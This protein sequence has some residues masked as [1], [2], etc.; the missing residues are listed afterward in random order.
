MGKGGGRFVWLAPFFCLLSLFLGS[1]NA[2]ASPLAL[3]ELLTRARSQQ[4]GQDPAWQRL[5]FYSPYAWLGR[6]GVIDDPNFYA[7]PEGKT[8]PQAELEATL[9]GFFSAPLS[10]P[11]MHPLCHYPARKAWLG[12]RLGIADKDW[13]TQT[14]PRLEAWKV[15]RSY[16]GLS[17][18]FSSFYPDN[19]PSMF[20]HLFLRLH[21]R[22]SRLNQSDL[23]DDTI[24]FAAHIDT[25]NPLVYAYKGLLGGFPGRFSFL[26]YYMKLQEYTNLE[27]RD[28]WEYELKI[29]PGQ[30]QDLLHS[31][32]EFGQHHADYYYFDDN[33]SFILLQLLEAAQ[34]SWNF[35]ADIKHWATPSAGLKAVIHTPGVVEKH[36]FVPSALSRY[37]ARFD[38]LSKSEAEILAELLAAKTLGSAFSSMPLAVESKKLVIDAAF[39]FIDFKEKLAGNHQAEIYASLRQELIRERRTLPRGTRALDKEPPFRNPREGNPEGWLMLGGGSYQGAARLKLS[40]QPVLQDLLSDDAGY[41]AGMQLQIMPMELNYDLEEQGLNLGR[42][43]VFNITSLRGKERLMDPASWTFRLGWEREG[44]CLAEEGA[45]SQALVATSRGFAQSFTLMPGL[46]LTNAFLLGLQGAH[47]EKDFY[48]MLAPE[49]LLVFD[50]Q[51]LVKFQ[52]RLLGGRRWFPGKSQDIRQ[53]EAGLALLLDPQWNLRGLYRQAELAQD[54]RVRRQEELS[55]GVLT[56]F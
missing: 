50:W 19:P 42:F 48:G 36:R 34:P 22:Q 17:I 24:S 30:I 27:S 40:W 33:C 52:G 55:L 11:N 54:G 13:P 21:R 25:H 2:P 35:T 26:P 37:K 38:Q 28:L 12:R 1:T 47:R 44:I 56:Y 45:C 4:L 14:C 3:E 23:L 9:V 29:E 39:E 46:G 20:G 53:F 18:V 32:W 43:D 8:D 41:A 49:W 6:R 31:L 7:S 51:R 16:E 5:L 10:D 15:G